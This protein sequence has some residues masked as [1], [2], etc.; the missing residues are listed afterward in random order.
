MMEGIK[1][2]II[3]LMVAAIVGEILLMIAPQGNVSKILK[4]AVSVFFL[5]CFL[6]PFAALGSGGMEQL[7]FDYQ[8]GVNSNTSALDETMQQQTLVQ[9]E[10]NIV[11]IAVVN[12]KDLDIPPQKIEAE[13]NMQEDNS[14]QIDCI[15]IW[16]DSS[17][18]SR[19]KAAAD[20]L[21]SVFGYKTQLL[22]HY[23]EEPT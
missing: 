14:I 10:K 5:G 7:S 16:L 4:V 15:N 8:S 21:H 3:A 9:F 12:L 13:V 11:Q 2:W 6:T 23:G 20:Q 17:Y 18:Q 19:E 1:N 22:F